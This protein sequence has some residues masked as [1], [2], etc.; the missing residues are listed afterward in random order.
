MIDLIK[1]NGRKPI[2]LLDDV[3]SEFD[4]TKKRT[5]SYVNQEDTDLYH[6][7]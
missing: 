4:K 7:G 5:I 2:L 3:F 1:N 6:H